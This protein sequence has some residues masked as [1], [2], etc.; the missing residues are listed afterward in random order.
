VIESAES[1]LH[2]SPDPTRGPGK[3]R[4]LI[5]FSGGADSTA[6]ADRIAALN[7]EREL[8]CIHV[9]HQLDKDSSHRADRAGEIARQIGL[10]CIIE[11][12]DV[13]PSAS[14][15]AAARKARYAA[16]GRYVAADDILLTAHHAD[17]QVETVLLRLLRGA[18]PSGLGGIPA[19]RRFGAGWLMRPLL[20]RSR[21]EIQDYCRARGLDWIEDPA[22]RCLSADR[23]FLR[24]Q[25]LPRLRS[26]WPGLDHGV[27]RSARLAAE[28]G[29]FVE[30]RARAVLSD[31]R[32]DDR[33]LLARPLREA[34]PHLQA[35]ALRLWCQ[36]I[37]GSTPPGKQLDAFLEQIDGC[38]LDRLPELRWGSAVL[39]FWSERFWV[40]QD[41]SRQAFE[42]QWSTARAL[43][44]PEGLGEL[45]LCG[46]ESTEPWSFRVRSGSPGE[47]IRPAHSDHHRRV[48]ELMRVE[49]VPP[50]ERDWWPRIYEGQDL[51][52]VGSRWIDRD[53]S[54]RLAGRG[55]KLVWRALES[56]PSP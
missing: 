4:L 43:R 6:L 54:Q 13:I 50:W 31:G 53:F 27:R 25:I 36:D 1:T 20:E 29:L 40:D 24:H 11:R 21:A 45:V 33:V 34:G 23:N 41:R 44:L 26:R 18:G 7:S 42:L 15:E 5:A 9:D 38:P 51:I 10:D 35:E 56:H 37:V 52:A 12:I 3:G 19:V 22:N 32:Q 14:P 30:D 39:R 28:A 55:L 2:L 47:R 46:E 49:G 48:G 16:L 8:L 17:D